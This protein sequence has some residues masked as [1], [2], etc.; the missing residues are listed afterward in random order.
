MGHLFQRALGGGETDALHPA[1]G[2]RL[3]PL[4]RERQV[5]PALGGHDRVDLIDDHRVD[6]AQAG[7]GIRGKQQ[8]QRLRGS[9]QNLCRMPPEP[10]SF[11]L[12]CVTGADTD[13]RLVKSDS[14]LPGHIRDARQG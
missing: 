6:A 1:L 2:D 5:R 3:Q 13:L 12:R 9:D 7:G 4:E 10:A 14:C 8:I 11:L